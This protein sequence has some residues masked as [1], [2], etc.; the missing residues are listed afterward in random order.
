MRALSFGGSGIV[1]TLGSPR[2]ELCECETEFADRAFQSEQAPRTLVDAKVKCGRRTVR[3]YQ[4]SAYGSGR[5][6]AWQGPED[7]GPVGG[8]PGPRQ[9]SARGRLR[10]IVGCP[11]WSGS[12][13]V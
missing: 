13:P 3:A 4:T 11:L 6:G 10:Q 2:C 12:T 5:S 1:S 7:V 8:P 9:H